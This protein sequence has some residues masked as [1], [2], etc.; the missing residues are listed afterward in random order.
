MSKMFSK[1]RLIEFLLENKFID[2][3]KQ[4]SYEAFG[5]KV[6]AFIN[7]GSM[8]QRYSLENALGSVGQKVSADYWPGHA[9]VCT[10]VKY[11]K[12]WH[13]DE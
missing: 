10:D 6:N 12:A 9:T 11:F 4:V 2:S 7:V 3:D 13:W 8:V 1:K 5:R